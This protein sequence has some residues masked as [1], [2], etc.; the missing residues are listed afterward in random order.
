MPSLG[1]GIH[2]LDLFSVQHPA[3]AASLPTTLCV[4]QHAMHSD[5]AYWT[6]VLEWLVPPRWT[7]LS[8]M[9]NVAEAETALRQRHCDA[10]LAAGAMQWYRACSVSPASN[11]TASM[12]LVIRLVGWLKHCNLPLSI[13]LGCAAEPLCQHQST[14]YGGKAQD[15][16]MQQASF[17]IVCYY[18]VSEY[19]RVESV[20]GGNPPAASPAS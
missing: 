13:S 11:R 20:G 19:G 15:C 6:S 1:L 5:E 16:Y 9:C 2:N 7:G 18:R 10:T 12:L 17:H 4:D 8:I 3:L 14:K